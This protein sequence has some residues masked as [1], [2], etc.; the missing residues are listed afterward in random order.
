MP[1]TKIAL[2][3]L[4]V[5]SLPGPENILR[6]V[7]PNGI[8]VLARE[9]FSSPSV[10]VSG[11]VAVGAL[12]EPDS[13]AGLANL[14]AS[15]LTRGTA[16][17]TFEAIYE[18]IESIG[19]SISFSA[20]KHSTSFHGKSLAEDLGVLLGILAEVVREP[21][22]PATE[23]DRL[24]AEK[25][26]AL[27]IRDQDTGSVA[28]LEFD[29]MVY[30]GHPYRV[31]AEGWRET[32][33]TLTADDVTAF[34]RRTYGPRGLV[35]SVV[36]AVDRVSAVAAVDRA[37]GDWANSDQA[38][39]PTLPALGPI[40]GIVRRERSLPGKSQCDLVLGV[41]GPRRVDPDYLAAALGN[42]VLGRFGMYGRI[43][44]AVREA[45]GLAYYAYSALSGG[46]GPGPWSV[47]AGV[48]PANVDRAITLIR[49]EI[50]RFVT[51]KV[52]A[53]ELRENQANFIGRV[54]LQLESNEGVASALVNIE[55]YQ[56]GLD[57]YPRYPERIAAISRE[58]VLETARRFLNPDRLA[59]AVAGP[60]LKSA[61]E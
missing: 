53:E 6:E 11:Y 19:A 14:T 22:F 23:V 9:N 51:R 47:L 16:R 49:Q 44:D 58:A 1:E 34:H 20:G 61:Q 15:A 41:A 27:A 43:G 3:R 39:E 38:A 55:R 50:G 28:G 13:Q 12:H 31:P 7:L 30:G 21:T 2:P 37:L 8:V 54:P 25:L 32:V 35:L 59:I 17:R 26:T 24:R 36:G 57:Y 40:L 56:L 29:G 10:V 46:P 60:P 48:N 18:S 42:N 4:D 5:R 33:E 45:A 52:S